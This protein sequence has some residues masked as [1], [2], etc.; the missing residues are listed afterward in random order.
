MP[1]RTG[2]VAVLIAVAA[3]CAG[4]ILFVHFKRILRQPVAL[5]TNAARNSSEVRDALGE[6]LR[7][8]RLPEAK[9]HD[10]NAHLA[11]RVRGPRGSGLLLEWAQRDAGSWQLCSLLFRDESTTTDVILVSRAATHCAR[12]QPGG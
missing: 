11:I 2:S 4:A 6:P 9:L 1:R 5:A 7:F 8:G 10:T 3:L 12:E